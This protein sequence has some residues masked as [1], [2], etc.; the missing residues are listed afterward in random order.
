LVTVEDRVRWGIRTGVMNVC[1][2]GFDTSSTNVKTIEENLGGRV[3]AEDGIYY[4]FNLERN[5]SRSFRFTQRG[6]NTVGNI[7]V[8]M[9][10]HNLTSNQV[11]ARLFYTICG[12]SDPLQCFLND[13]QRRG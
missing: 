2:Y 12:V 3:D 4:T 1:L 8:T 9:T 10:N 7:S 5:N 11:P 6:F 13:T